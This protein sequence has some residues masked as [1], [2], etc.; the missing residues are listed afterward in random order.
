MAWV[1][2]GDAEP[3]TEVRAIRAGEAHVALAHAGGAWHAFSDDCTHHECPLSDGW[4]E[5]TTIECACHGSVFDVTT[6]AAVRGPATEPIAVFPVVVR[7]G[8]VWVELS[9]ST[10]ADQEHPV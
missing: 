4:L 9:P 10:D 2:A 6:G 5:G 7:D 3:T 8:L 1:E